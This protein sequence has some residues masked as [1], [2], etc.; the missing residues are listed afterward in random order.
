MIGYGKKLKLNSNS[1]RDLHDHDQG[2]QD[3]Y[4]EAKVNFPMSLHV[5]SEKDHKLDQN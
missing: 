1:Q 3:K 4:F 2:S 5:I